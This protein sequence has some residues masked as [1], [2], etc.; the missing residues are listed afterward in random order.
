MTDGQTFN[1]FAYVN[2]A[3]IGFIDPLG[4]MKCKD[5]TAKK[6]VTPATKK[7]D[8][9]GEYY[10]TTIRFET[11]V[12]WGDEYRDMNRRD[13]NRKVKYLQKLS[14]ANLLRKVKPVRD[15]ELTKKYKAAVIKKIIK[16]YYH[17]DKELAKKLIDKVRDDLDPDHMWDL[18][19]DG[20]DV[21][22]NLKLMDQ[23]TNRRLGGV[24]GVQLKD[25]PYGS[26][27]KIKI[28]R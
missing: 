2:G 13:F 28:E 6:K 24:L 5:E 4:L 18:G 23:F 16:H 10:E 8:E 26:R 12:K 1:R 9:L 14:D 21:K 17:R 25:V 19:L 27:I 11:N 20:P 15:Q 22:R 7:V 3:P